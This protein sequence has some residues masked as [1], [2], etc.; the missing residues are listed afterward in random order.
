MKIKPCPFCGKNNVS[1]DVVFP[2]D[3]GGGYGIT[4]LEDNC[5]GSI[6]RHD[7]FYA[8]EEGAIKAWN[9]RQTK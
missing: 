2:N 5:M 8:T 3:D 7:G 9:K 4:C 1:V 6:F